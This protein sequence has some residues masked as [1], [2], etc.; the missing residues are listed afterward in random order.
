M[1]AAVEAVRPICEAVRTRGAEA[2]AEL[3][4]RFDGVAPEHLRVPAGGPGRRARRRSTLPSGRG[5]R[6]RSARLRRHLRGRAGARRRHRARAGRHASPTGWCRSRRVGL[7]VP[8]GLAPLVSS[9]VMN[10]VPA[11]VAGVASLA[12]AS[13][14][15]KDHGG[16]PAPDDPGGVCAARRRRGVRRRRGAGDRDVRLRRGGVRAGRPGHRTRQHLHRRGQAAAQ[17]R[18]RHRLRGRTHRDR[19]PG[20]R[21]RRR[22]V[23]RRR[24]DQPGRARPGWPPACWSRPRERLADDVEAELEKQ[25]LATRHT[26]RIRTALGGQ[27]SA[28][29]L[30]DDLEQGLAV[31]DAYAAEHLEIQT[32]DA[33]ARGR[34]GAQRRRDLRRPVRPGVA[35]RLLRRLQPRAAHGRLCLPLL[36]PVGARVPQGGPRR[37]LR[38]RRAGRGRRPRRHA[39]RGRGPA[40]ATAQA[41]TIRFGR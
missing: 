15:Q 20:R 32:E 6:S 37:R 12:L 8:G 17:G 30:V 40:R 11:Q 18:R 9:V 23:R 38:P 28:I 19:D 14:P 3:S 35:R 26:E 41:V 25:V 24:P 5:S 7:Y 29:V 16:L 39:R 10:V 34:P 27:Q 2:I 13:S 36:R 21:Q 1:E 31:V 33:A 22:G 4:L